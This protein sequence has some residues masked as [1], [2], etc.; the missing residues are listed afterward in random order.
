MVARFDR[1]TTW[2][3]DST[4]TF[5]ILEGLTIENSFLMACINIAA[6]DGSKESKILQ[7]LSIRS[8]NFCNNILVSSDRA[9]QDSKSRHSVNRWT[10]R[11]IIYG[12]GFMSNEAN[13]LM[14]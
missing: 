9:D 7:T 12:K 4:R 13:S 11:R 2:I 10:D 14:H 6:Q 1:E 8:D 5:L 3:S